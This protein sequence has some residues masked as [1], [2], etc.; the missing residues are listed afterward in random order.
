MLGAIAHNLINITDTA[1]MGRVGTVELAAVGISG[2]YYFVMVM[3]CFGM[4]TAAQILIA[5]RMGEGRFKEIGPIFTHSFYLLLVLASLLFVSFKFFTPVFFNLVFK[6]SEVLEASIAYL[7]YRAWGIFFVAIMNVFRGFYMGI[8]KT[9]VITW[10]TAAMA[11]INIV[12]DYGLI[13]GKLGMPE[14][15]IEGAALASVIAEGV[16][17]AYFLGYTWIK[18]DPLKY[19][20]FK[21]RIL[22]TKLLQK[23]I[24]VSSPL[25]MQYL[26]SL[27]AW[28]G[29]FLFIEQMGPRALA[30]SNILKSIYMVF[31]IPIWGFSNATATLV[32]NV[33]GQGKGGQVIRLLGKIV[34][35]DLGISAGLSLI[36]ALF[37]MTLMKVYSSDIALIQSGIPSMY[38]LALAL[39]LFAVANIYLNGII[40]TG[41]TAFALFCE[42][43]AITL[44][45]IY[46]WIVV[47]ELNLSLTYVW[48]SEFVY[49]T[50]LL[51]LPLIYL[52][53]GR[54]KK[55]SL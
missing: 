16:A 14:M 29:F 30:V 46:V 12:L 28:F 42:I 41:A 7:D 38:V 18:I 36:L 17:V 40:G 11:L 25:M 5:R 53:S 27:G 33:I 15:G 8:A 21:F 22:N 48:S 44:Y 23:L 37:P 49:W 54:W 13:F 55:L 32:S 52:W 9:L 45:L 39:L 1:F 43:I 35:L 20:L 31:M 47:I 2:V 51:I 4:G 3:I 26:V 24:R 19:E 10:S 50:V 34:L 6:S